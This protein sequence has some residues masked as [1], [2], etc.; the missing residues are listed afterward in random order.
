[1][2]RWGKVKVFVDRRVVDIYE[3]KTDPVHFSPNC[4]DPVHFAL[5]GKHE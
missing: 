4:T 2:W 5:L 3:K 1:M